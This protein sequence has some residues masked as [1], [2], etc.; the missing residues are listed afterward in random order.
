MCMIKARVHP[1]KGTTLVAVLIRVFQ[2][3]IQLD[4]S[5]LVAISLPSAIAVDGWNHLIDSFVNSADEQALIIRS[6]FDAINP[7]I[8]DRVGGLA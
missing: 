4:E 8:V 7:S 3:S 2:D 6:T 1:S 5:N